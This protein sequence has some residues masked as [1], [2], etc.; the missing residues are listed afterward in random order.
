MT[1]TRGKCGV[2]LLIMRVMGAGEG[3][4]RRD[5]VV[6]TERQA[7]IDFETD[8]HPE[9]TEI[10]LAVRKDQRE[11]PEGVLKEMCIRR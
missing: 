8:D 9:A 2:G 3:V 6:L 10:L 7:G 11:W 1:A 4:L 5:R